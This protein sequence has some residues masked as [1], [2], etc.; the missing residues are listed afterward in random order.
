VIVNSV[1]TPPELRGRGYAKAVIA[2]ALDIVEKER[3]QLKEAVLFASL[4]AAIRTYEYLGFK[5]IGEWGLFILKDEFRL[6]P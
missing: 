3:P 6:T 2:G 1:W 5:R 4:P